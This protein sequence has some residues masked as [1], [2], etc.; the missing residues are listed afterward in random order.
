C[1]Q[2]AKR[3]RGSG[4]SCRNQ[5]YMSPPV[6]IFLAAGAAKLGKRFS[7]RQ[8]EKHKGREGSGRCRAIYAHLIASIGSGLHSAGSTLRT[9]VLHDRRSIRVPLAALR[10]PVAP[11]PQ[12]AATLQRSFGSVAVS[13]VQIL[14]ARLIEQSPK[15][16]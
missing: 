5:C 6:Q 12:E 4:S 16:I 1:S 2:N 14:L 9:A 10:S 11:L 13:L 7:P 15:T 8:G 3:E